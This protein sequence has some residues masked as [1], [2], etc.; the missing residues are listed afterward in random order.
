MEKHEL[1]NH[2]QLWIFRYVTNLATLKKIN[3]FTVFAI[4]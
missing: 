3:G 4:F 2:E 1:P